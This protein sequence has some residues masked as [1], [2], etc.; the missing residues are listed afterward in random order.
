MLVGGSNPASNKHLHWRNNLCGCS[1]VGFGYAVGGEDLV[2]ENNVLIWGNMNSQTFDPVSWPEYPEDDYNFWWHDV[3]YTTTW[4]GLLT[5][6]PEDGVPIPSTPLYKLH[7]NEYDVDRA[8]VG[9][10]GFNGE[11]SVTVDV[12]GWL[13]NGDQ[14]E[15][16]DPLDRWGAAVDTGSVSGGTITVPFTRTLPAFINEPDFRFDAYIIHKISAAPTAGAVQRIVIG[17]LD[18]ATIDSAMD[19]Q[20]IAGGVTLSL[21]E[22]ATPSGNTLT[23]VAGDVQPEGVDTSLYNIPYY[24][25]IV[26][27][28]TV[29]MIE[30]FRQRIVGGAT[31][32]AQQ[33]ATVLPTLLVSVAGD[34]LGEGVSQ[35]LT[36]VRHRIPPSVLRF[37]G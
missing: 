1:G 29:Q 12:S 20:V 10:V 23:S 16:L 30:P 28:A 37:I 5:P 24:V 2:V 36:A 7:L 4:S 18:G 22:G 14:Y 32:D 6:N 15:L 8:H 3:Y 31:V 9:A 13:N 27:D 21:G 17:C 33:S 19:T 35:L 34:V 25:R 11:S 26:G